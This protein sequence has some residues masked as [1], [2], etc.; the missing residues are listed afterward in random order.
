MQIGG[1]FFEEFDKQG[2]TSAKLL[3]VQVFFESG[4]EHYNRYAIGLFFF[5]YQ[6]FF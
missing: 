1:V 6:R 4:I 2:Y 3:E 5:S